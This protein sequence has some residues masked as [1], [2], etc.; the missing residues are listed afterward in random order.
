MLLLRR[1]GSVV[2]RLPAAVDARLGGRRVVALDAG[3]LT[4]HAALTAR[5]LHRVRLARKTEPLELADADDELAVVLL[6]GR[7]RLV[8]LADGEQLE[9]RTQ[10]AMTVAAASLEADGLLGQATGA[11]R[12]TIYVTFRNVSLAMSFACGVSEAFRLGMPRRAGA[13]MRRSQLGEFT[14]P[15]FFASCPGRGR[16]VRRRRAPP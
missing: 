4:V 1:D 11:P 6:G 7:L 13:P 15:L 8:R 16:P 9:L 2:Q 5:V 14:R 3:T 12:G 10:P